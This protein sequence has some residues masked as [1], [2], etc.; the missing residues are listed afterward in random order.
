MQVSLILHNNM[1]VDPFN[2]V[3][4]ITFCLFFVYYI[5]YTLYNAIITFMGILR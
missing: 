2:L 4:A 5:Y 1:L 3:P